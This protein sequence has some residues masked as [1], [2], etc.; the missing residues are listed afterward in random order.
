MVEKAKLKSYKD[1]EI[2]QQSFK[3]ALKAH[4]ITLYLPKYELFEEGSQLRR[5]A[6]SIT[7]N[8][9]E[10]YG[11]RRYKSEFIRYL[12]FSNS[13]CDETIIHLHFIRDTH[14]NIELEI[15]QLITD[16]NILGGKI[17][18]YIQYVENQWR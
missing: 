9:V 11:R 6:K 18:K 13:S 7:A 8:I 3:L 17:N 4:K 12:V 5:A 14:K 1:L 15:E 10:G 2:F 16:Y